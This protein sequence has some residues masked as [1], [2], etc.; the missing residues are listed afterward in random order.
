[1]NFW[2]GVLIFVLGL[3]ISVVLHEAGHFL[4]ARRFGMKATE[5]FVGFGP[6]MWSCR[7][8]ET[9]YG[10]KWILVG[11]YVKILGMTPL[12]PLSEADRPRAFYRQ[13]GWRRA[14]VL[15]SGSIVNVVLAFLLFALVVMVLGRP[16]AG[17]GTNVVERV[18]PCVSAASAEC[19]PGDPPSP[20]R[21]AGLRPG[22]RIVSLAGK[23]TPDW[24]HLSE[25]IQRAPA[26][27]VPVVV[28][29]GGR[30]ETLTVD[31]V[32]APDG[33]RSFLGVVARQTPGRVEY[34][35]PVE[36]VAFA[37]RMIGETVGGIVEVLASLPA[38]LP[39]LF[40]PE[41]GD[42][43]GGQVSSIV[44]A[45]QISGELGELG[46]TWQARVRAWLLLLASLNMFVGMF[47]L[48][49]LLPL[50][51]G[52]LAV[53]AYERTRAL[54]ARRRNLPDPGPVDYQKLA[55]VTVL[56]FVL[57][58]GLGLLLIAADIT[59]PLKVLQ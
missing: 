42:T 47:N 40:T 1:M 21:A 29:R 2:L 14:V 18:S 50:D 41:R 28:E 16:V 6:R 31:L 10:F 33:E 17:K 22:D 45:A 48:L 43:A 25:T 49:P 24:F 52:H 3:T 38:A 15:V 4:F 9:E 30:T 8:G 54:V 11:G 36:A 34:Y 55:P 7:R 35:G 59:N 5:F 32:R 46:Q 39:K 13:R 57:L 23:P 44:G 58:L 26:G 12:E 27:R 20:A 19:G 56:G 37:G 51:G 53:L